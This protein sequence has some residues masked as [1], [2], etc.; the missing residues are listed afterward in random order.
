MPALLMYKSQIRIL[1]QVTLGPGEKTCGSNKDP[2]FDYTIKNLAH[3]KPL[4]GTIHARDESH[5]REILQARWGIQIKFVSITQSNKPV[6]KRKRDR[7][8]AS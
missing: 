5:L 4:N 1:N 8:I 3:G 2:L 6:Q 7:A